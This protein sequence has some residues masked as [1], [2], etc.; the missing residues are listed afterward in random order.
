MRCRSVSVLALVLLVKT[1]VAEP[2][3]HAPIPRK[4]AEEIQRLIRAT[5]REPLVC[6]MP[7]SVS[8]RFRGSVT[9]IEYQYDV[10]TGTRKNL[11][12]RT[13]C[14]H[15]LTG[16]GSRGGGDFYEVQKLHGKWKITS[17][18]YWGI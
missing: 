10:K 5:T 15:V 1:A 16:Y 12:S 4:D 7:V 2:C 17:K 6:I 9:G 14:V 3:V 18:G 11:Y 13:D 8:Q